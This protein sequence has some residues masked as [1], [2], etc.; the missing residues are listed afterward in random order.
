MNMPNTSRS[1]VDCS[2]LVHSPYLTGFV[3]TKDSRGYILKDGFKVLG[4]NFQIDP[5]FFEYIYQAFEALVQSPEIP[6]SIPLCITQGWILIL[7]ITQ[8][9]SEYSI[10]PVYM[11]D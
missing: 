9:I 10:G 5:I 8:K 6:L 11:E 7:H 3:K 4:L 2:H 1:E